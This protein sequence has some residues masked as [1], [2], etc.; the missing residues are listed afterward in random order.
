MTKRGFFRGFTRVLGWWQRGPG[1]Q[2]GSGPGRSSAAQGA[3]SHA[4]Q[5][6]QQQQ[7]QQ[8]AGQLGP[9]SLWGRE[10]SFKP[11]TVALLVLSSAYIGSQAN[12]HWPELQ[13]H[14]PLS[15]AVSVDNVKATIAGADT[16]TLQVG[17]L[18]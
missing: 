18:P 14:W 6:S 13:P 11:G 5:A 12:R 7:Q 16:T 4:S 15:S 8:Q 3:R 10:V 2:L 17:G 9:Q 1:E